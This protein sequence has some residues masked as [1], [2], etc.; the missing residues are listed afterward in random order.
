MPIVLSEKIIF[1][2][3]GKMRFIHKHCHLSP[4]SDYFSDYVKAITNKGLI[5]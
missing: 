4:S 1:L 2:L 3:V 5:M